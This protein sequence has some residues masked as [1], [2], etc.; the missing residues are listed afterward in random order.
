LQAQ[1][2]GSDASRPT[3]QQETSGEDEEDREAQLSERTQDDAYNQVLHKRK[4][5]SL[6]LRRKNKA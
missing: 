4:L 6:F 3:Y 1:F 2:D 5:Y